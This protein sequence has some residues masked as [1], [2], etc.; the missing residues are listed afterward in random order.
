MAASQVLAELAQDRVQSSS[1][2]PREPD[3]TISVQPLSQ[4]DTF[5]IPDT[6]QEEESSVFL[7]ESTSIRYVTHGFPTPSDA[8]ASTP[9][10][11]KFLHLVPNAVRAENLIPQW[12]VERRQA[13]IRSLRAEGVFSF[14]PQ[15]AVEAL[16]RTYFQ[17]FHPCFP[18][19]D[20][21][22][23]WTQYRNGV[24]SPLLLQAIL[25]IAVMHCDEDVLPA[26]NHGS[27]HMAKYVFY[28]R[29]KDIYD[30]DYEAKKFTVT[31]ALFLMSFWRAGALLEKDARHWL[32]AAIS[33]AQTKALHRSARS[34]TTEKKTNKLRRRLWWSIYTRERQCAAA[35][36]LPNRI[37]DEDCD[38]AP[39]DERD[40]EHAFSPDTA[41]AKVQEYI[42]YAV[43]MA[44][45]S[46]V[47]GMIV[48]SGYL[49]SKSLTSSGR[50][51]MK[52]DLTRWRQ[53]LPA[54]MQRG[55]DDL[56]GPPGFYANML[57]LA[58]NNLLILLY[59]SG[60]IGSA[61]ESREVD[62][63]IALQA[64]ARNSS[65]M[66]DMLLEGNL[67]H[68][69]IH[70][71]TNLFNTLCI[72]TV[73]LRASVGTG[74][75]IL[76]HR[77]KLCLLG[78]QELQK[79]WEG[80]NWVLQLFFQYLDRSTAARLRMQDDS[81]ELSDTQRHPAAAVSD[82][83]PDS[84]DDMCRSSQRLPQPLNADGLDTLLVS[85]TPW[86]WSTEEA[87]QFLF[88]QIEKDF[89]F[90]EGGVLDW[91]PGTSSNAA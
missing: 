60:C 91:S 81:N 89:A 3:S 22:D 82:S 86:S 21:L 73:S 75:A 83:R 69:Q 74:R 78:L 24:L 8:G 65:I 80:R 46:R 36:G 54:I 5:A 52:D 58:Y 31:Q 49:P 14:P 85:D 39:L 27:R 13:R 19:V 40:F 61:E 10:N 63:K 41:S 59:R 62:G 76:E 2:D 87:N 79:T 4:L 72:H 42:A 20:E 45:L 70:V 34:T 47:L 64:A 33:L 32:G 30:V 88:S 53:N 44:Q 9:E 1:L 90:G 77:A 29:A 66:E 67:R 18:I 55:V 23:I 56:D 16:L 15:E 6:R 68:G 17:W 25:F 26:L 7:G 51:Q 57:H 37:R 43:G 12:E 28:N 38:I 71:I 50:S 48:H 84:V 11:L 35:L